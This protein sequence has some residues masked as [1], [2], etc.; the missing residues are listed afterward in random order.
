MERFFF[1]GYCSKP[2]HAGIYEIENIV[3]RH[4]FIL[5]FKRFSDLSMNM[6]IE[7]QKSK[8]DSLYREL[9]SFMNMDNFKYLRSESE[10]EVLVFLNI[11]FREGSG[12]ME[13]EVPEV[14]G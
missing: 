7:I 4:G 3:G 12:T 10:A 1:N 11:V 5:N 13:I 8:I 14:P 6:V 9:C 2:R